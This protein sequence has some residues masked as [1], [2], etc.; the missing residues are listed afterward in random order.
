M[1]CKLRLPL[2][3]LALALTS[4]P[5]TAHAQFGV[6]GMFSVNRLTGIQSSPLT[7]LYIPAGFTAANAFNDDVN[8]L[9]FTGGAYYDF[10]TFGPVRL[11]ADLRGSIV[12]SKRG[13]EVCCDGAGTRIESGLGGVR[14]SFS[15]PK[16]W[17]KPYVQASAGIGR[18]NYG[19][20]TPSATGSGLYDNL[21]YHGYAGVDLAIVPYADWRVF[22]VGYGALNSFGSSS[23]TYPLKSI[24]TGVVFHFGGP[25]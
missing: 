24:T 22:E 21:E 16:K 1:I 15:T 6:Y 8:P 20:S 3:V 17:L 7:A 2:A 25:Q 12:T 4:L 19:I 11:G 18:S 5:I 10:K 14:A 9:G 13:A 23:H